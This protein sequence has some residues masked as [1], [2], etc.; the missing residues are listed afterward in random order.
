M[1]CQRYI[2]PW[3]VTSITATRQQ[4][5]LPYFEHNIGEYIDL[6]PRHRLIL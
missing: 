6:D 2:G 5:F 4:H 3:T 1:L